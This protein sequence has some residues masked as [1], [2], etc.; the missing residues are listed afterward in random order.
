MKS[1]V[2]LTYEIDD[3]K[4]AAQEL[5]SGI[6]E[7][8]N[9]GK[10]TFGIIHCDADVDVEELSKLLHEDLGC[11]IVGLTTTALIERSSG[12]CDMGIVLAVITGDDIDISIGNTNELTKLEFQDQIKS[13]YSNAR[14][15]LPEDPKLILVC[16]PY[17]PDITSEKYL[18]SL[19]ELSGH[20]PIFGGVATDHYD[21]Q[22]Q[23][24]FHNGNAYSSGLIFILLTG[25]IKPVFAMQHNFGGKIKRKGIIT[26]STA[27]MV[28][29]IDDKTFVQFLSEI[30]PIPDDDTV[31]YQFQS[32]PF[33]MELPDRVKD[34]QPVVRALCSIDHETG[35]GGFLSKMPEGSALSI[36]IIQRDNLA[37]S[38]AETLD[39]LLE[40]MQQSKDDYCMILISSCNARHLLMGD[41]KNLEAKIISDRLADV[42]PG[43][44]AIGFY[45]FGEMCPTV[46]SEEEQAKNRFHNISFALCAF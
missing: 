33:I 10:S 43:L 18:E 45:G 46:F 1:A 23:K 24:T 8:I 20:A 25:N 32:T 2:M 30:T 6:R 36:N 28:N 41:K 38:C 13:A 40:K 44:N 5:A 21:L 35:S 4:V 15:I 42:E 16:A 37:F 9:F 14:S 31:I 29:Q 7:K 3:V 22:Y 12:Y 19:D 39:H 27:N 11:E 17:I 34:E 26:K